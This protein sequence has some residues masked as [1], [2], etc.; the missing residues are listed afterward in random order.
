MATMTPTRASLGRVMK[1]GLFSL[2][3]DFEFHFSL[4]VASQVEKLTKTQLLAFLDSCKAK[5]MKARVEP[6][7][8]E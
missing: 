6:G 2:L 8:S 3:N 1:V 5:Y 7:K 4:L